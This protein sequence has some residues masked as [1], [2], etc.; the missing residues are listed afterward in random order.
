MMLIRYTDGWLKWLSIILFFLVFLSFDVFQELFFVPSLRTVIGIYYYGFFPTFLI[1]FILSIVL[2]WW[3]KDS[4]HF[5]LQNYK[6]TKLFELSILLGIGFGYY[7][8]SV[9]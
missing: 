4:D 2:G 3:V 7:M 8:Y 1:F 5:N 9:N 6:Y